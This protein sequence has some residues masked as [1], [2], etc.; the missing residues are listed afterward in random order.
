M[1]EVRYFKESQVSYRIFLLAL[2]LCSMSLHAQEDPNLAAAAANQTA[3]D[4]QPATTSATPPTENPAVDET[5]AAPAA[6][7]APAADSTAERVPLSPED[8]LKVNAPRDAEEREEML[9]RAEQLRASA[10]E[11]RQAAEEVHNAAQ[12][13]CWKK[14]LVSSCLEDA[15]TAYRKEI[16]QA[17]HDERQAQT[18]QRN[19][20]RYD[21]AEHIRQRDAENAKREADNARKAA[22]YRV[23]RAEELERLK[24]KGVP[25]KPAAQ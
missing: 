25:V 13:T 23:K 24:A 1:C 9:Q 15:R 16:S 10:A 19:V 5:G 11:R 7:G 3:A 17:K 8:L 21:A 22:D 4:A 6:S 20:R 12:T 2:S 14:F 18:L